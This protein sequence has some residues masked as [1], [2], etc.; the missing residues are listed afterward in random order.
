MKRYFRLNHAIVAFAAALFCVGALSS[1]SAAAQS[2]SDE[3]RFRAFV[4]MWAP[5]ITTTVTFPGGNV[6]HSELKFHDILDHLKMT[7]MGSLEA[8]KGRW[9]AFTDVVYMNLGGTK[10]T[11]RDATINGVPLP[12]G[13]TANTGLDLKSWIWTLAASYRVQSTAESEMDVFAGARMLTLEP[14]LTWNFNVDVGP[15]VG[16]GRAGSSTVKQTDW[17]AIIGLKGRAGFGA[18]REWFI[19]Y[20]V[21]IGTGDTDLTW[22]GSAGI[23]Y[24]Y[25]WGEVIATWRYLD[26][27]FKK[28]SKVN[29]L[30]VNGPVLGVAFRW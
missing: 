7:G 1:G 15:F 30:T 10:T 20:Y 6:A 8:Q 14:R 4:Y 28:S 19:P 23:G 26:Y 18:N 27:K 2:L 16:P 3:W 24:I 22:Q 29:Y 17:D 12:V 21:D 5:R 13:V 9:G 25:P 11:T